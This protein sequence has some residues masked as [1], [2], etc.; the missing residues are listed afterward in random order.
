MSD[1]PLDPA[2]TG[3]LLG[4][5]AHDLRNPLSALRS[6]LGFIEGVIAQ[7]DDDLR[8]ALSDA[9]VSC[10]S[11]LRIIDNLDWLGRNLRGD[12]GSLGSQPVLG[13]VR[14][15]IDQN[16]A[17]AK[18]HESSL[19]L[20][21]GTADES[22]WVRTERLALTAAVS[23]LVR[24]GIQHGGRGPVRVRVDASDG[25]CTISV[26]DPGEPVPADVWE[27][28]ISAEGQLLAKKQ[29]GSRYGYG[30]GLFAASAAARAAGARLSNAAD[31]AGGSVMLLQLERDS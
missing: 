10:D 2:L 31:E 26:R 27:K 4:L 22:T 24:N 19:Q 29:S 18:S 5:A 14:D 25:V 11:L 21:E 7:D 6:N 15:A 20:D 28:A 30:F 17:L 9:F 23:N 12:L 13:M 1:A 3:A 8:E 16:M